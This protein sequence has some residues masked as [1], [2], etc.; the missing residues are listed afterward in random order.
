MRP[1]RHCLPSVCRLR[2]TSL[3]LGRRPFVWGRGVPFV[4]TRDY[5]RARGSLKPVSSSYGLHCKGQAHS[6]SILAQAILAQGFRLRGFVTPHSSRATS[7]SKGTP[8]HACRRRCC[9][10]AR[11]AGEHI[12][13]ECVVIAAHR[14]ARSQR[15]RARRACIGCS[16]R[17]IAGAPRVRAHRSRE[18]RHA[19]PCGLLR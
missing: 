18:R 11:A 2:V 17:A 14:N 13:L 7:A 9:W 8:F 3:F 16:G 12:A 6:V 19:G 5:V 15:A 10:A 1:F 4:R